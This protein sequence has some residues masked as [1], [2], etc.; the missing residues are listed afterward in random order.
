[1]IFFGVFGVPPA[2]FC[3]AK[4]MRNARIII[5]DFSF[6]KIRRYHAD[7]TKPL[8]R[9]LGCGHLKMTTGLSH[10]RGD[11]GVWRGDVTWLYCSISMFT[12]DTALKQQERTKSGP[13]ISKNSVSHIIP[14][15]P[16][17]TKKKQRVCPYLLFF[18][19]TCLRFDRTTCPPV[20]IFLVAL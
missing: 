8:T 19:G 9:L 15:F 20:K 4:Y 1:M 14:K 17:D 6:E 3:L 2:W 12:P 5:R 10:F 16:R 13:T 18:A 11:A 7:S